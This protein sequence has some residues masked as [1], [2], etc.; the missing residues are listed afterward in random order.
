MRICFDH[1]IVNE[2]AWLLGL[3]Q[4]ACGVV[5]RLREQEGIGDLGEDEMVVGKAWDYRFCMDLLQL[6]KACAGFY[7]S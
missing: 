1:G 3:N 5:Q 7:E 2:D 6:I 4:D